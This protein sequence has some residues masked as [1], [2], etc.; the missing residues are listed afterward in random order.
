MDQLFAIID[1]Y[2]MIKMP[3]E[4]DHH[5]TA[6]ISKTADEYIMNSKIKNVVF[7]FEETW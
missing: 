6:R 3:K 7:D 1:N 4:V 5:E 2:L